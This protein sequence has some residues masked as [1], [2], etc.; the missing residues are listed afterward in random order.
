MEK[1][2]I[3]V[4]INK[5]T[6]DIFSAT[7]KERGIPVSGLIHEGLRFALQWLGEPHSNFRV[8]ERPGFAPIATVSVPARPGN[9]A[10]FSRD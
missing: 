6:Y 7:A 9:S 4:A 5:E 2:R 8:P 10:F 3:N 1:Q